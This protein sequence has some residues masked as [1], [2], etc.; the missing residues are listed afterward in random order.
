[1]LADEINELARLELPIAKLYSRHRK[2]AAAQYPVR[3][4]ES[5]PTAHDE[6]GNARE[7]ASFDR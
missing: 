2:E 7:V 4:V 1:L 6:Y 5:L 3:K